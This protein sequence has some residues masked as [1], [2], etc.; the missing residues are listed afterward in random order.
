MPA[1]RVVAVI[2]VRV[3][4]V[5]GDA[6]V[7]VIAVRHRLVAAARTVNMA[8]LMTAAAMVRRAALRIGAGHL[9]HM[10][11]DMAVMRVVQVAVMQIVDMTAMPHGRMAAARPML[12]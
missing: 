11:I 8:G 12:V 3:M 9:Y 5:V 4:Q 10:L 7:D 6:V 2:A 1:A